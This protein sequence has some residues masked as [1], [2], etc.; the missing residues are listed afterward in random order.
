[1]W[2]KDVFPLGLGKHTFNSNS[3]T[4][5]ATL[6]IFWLD[7]LAY[8][9]TMALVKSSILFFY[10]SLFMSMSL[11]ASTP[12]LLQP[13]LWQSQ[14]RLFG[15]EDEFRRAIYFLLVLVNVIGATFFLV[16]LFQCNPIRKY[17]PYQYNIILTNTQTTGGVFDKS[18]EFVCIDNNAAALVSSGIS[19]AIDFAILLL[20]IPRVLRLRVSQQ[21]RNSVLIMFSFGLL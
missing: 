15:A 13:S 19:I 8:Q 6:F 7:E 4:I 12:C 10:V 9:V 14:L 5:K 21:R 18:I 11:Y 2:W 3:S 17:L 20:P 16:T 1:M